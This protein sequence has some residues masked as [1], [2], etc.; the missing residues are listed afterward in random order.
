M[1]QP[2]GFDGTNRARTCDLS[3]VKR[4][5]F[6]LSYGPDHFGFYPPVRNGSSRVLS[7]EEN[8]VYKFIAGRTVLSLSTI[9]SCWIE[10]I[11]SR[12]WLPGARKAVLRLGAFP[13]AGQQRPTRV[14]T[15]LGYFMHLTRQMK[16]AAGN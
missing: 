8:T 10:K 2:R 14:L 4:T 6:Q 15:Q 12:S 9:R 5:L 16:A 7:L 13:L 11:R 3:R 1:L